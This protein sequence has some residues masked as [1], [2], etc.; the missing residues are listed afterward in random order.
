MPIAS[1]RESAASWAIQ[2]DSIKIE[3]RQAAPSR[4]P[5]RSLFH[6]SQHGRRSALK[7]VVAGLLE[8]VECTVGK[9]FGQLDR[10][11]SRQLVILDTVQHMDRRADVLGPEIPGSTHHD[12]VRDDAVGALSYGLE[13][14]IRRILEGVRRHDRTICW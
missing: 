9:R 7:A 4:R 6:K 11:T 12:I 1:C 10:M 2:A 8:Q 13:E 5:V 3:A 14:E